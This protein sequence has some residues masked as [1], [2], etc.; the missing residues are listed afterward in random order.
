MILMSTIIK[1]DASEKFRE[2]LRGREYQ[3]LS[4]DLYIQKPL[5]IKKLIKEIPKRA[6]QL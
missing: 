5:Y 2:D 3:T 6:E 4:R 1:K